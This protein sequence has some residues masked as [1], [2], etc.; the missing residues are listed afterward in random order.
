MLGKNQFDKAQEMFTFFEENYD[1]SPYMV[2]AYELLASKEFKS[3]NFDR[4]YELNDALGYY[5]VNSH[6]LGSANESKI[7]DRGE[8]SKRQRLSMQFLGLEL[9]AE[10]FCGSNVPFSRI[11]GSSKI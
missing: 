2:A 7:D 10:V 6:W 8:F 4:A 9:S 5:G 3:A 1:T 11:L